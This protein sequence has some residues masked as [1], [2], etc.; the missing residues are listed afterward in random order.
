MVLGSIDFF[1]FS[2]KRILMRGNQCLTKWSSGYLK[3]LKK[4]Q[5]VPIT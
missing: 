5:G 3:D 2:L 1:F 4:F